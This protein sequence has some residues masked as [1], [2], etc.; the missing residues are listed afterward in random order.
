MFFIILRKNCIY[1]HSSHSQTFKDDKTVNANFVMKLAR[2]LRFYGQ[3]LH[4]RHIMGR[5][6]GTG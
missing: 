2:L 6:H 1:K 4:I 5:N 3:I